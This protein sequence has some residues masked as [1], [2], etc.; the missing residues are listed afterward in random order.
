MTVRQQAWTWGIAF[1]VFLGLLYLLGD[2]LTPF[3]AGMAIA[4]LLDPACDRLERMGCSR[5]VATCII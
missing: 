3:V 4:Y 5:I 1:A 2:V